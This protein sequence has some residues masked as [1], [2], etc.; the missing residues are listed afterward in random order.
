MVSSESQ[1]HLWLATGLVLISIACGRQPAVELDPVSRALIWEVQEAYDDHE[2]TYAL[3]LL[4][5]VLQRAPDFP[6]VYRLKGRVLSSLYRFDEADS[7][8]LRTRSLA[9][10]LP[11]VAFAMGN[12]AFF[13]GRYRRALHHY[14]SEVALL[15]RR[16]TT[17]LSATWAQMG[18]VYARLGAVDSARTAYQEALVHRPS[19]AQAWAWLAELDEQAGELE[20]ALAKA[21]H[22]VALAPDQPDFNYLAGSLSVRTGRAS[23]AEPYLATVLRVK[24]WH[25]GANYNMARCLLALG[26]TEEAQP[27]LAETDRLQTLQADIILARFAVERNPLGAEDWFALAELYQMSGRAEEAREAYAIVRQLN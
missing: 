4:D 5:S 11:G 14:R 20:E 8:Y 6:Q 1:Y 12:S 16:D 21:L 9:P 24:R 25:V 19:N 22:S 23:A 2:Y 7:A 27:F 18:R 13:R 3:V 10:T 26:R 17:A 15:P